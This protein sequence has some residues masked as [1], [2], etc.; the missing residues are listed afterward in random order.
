[1][2]PEEQHQEFINGVVRILSVRPQAGVMLLIASPVGLEIMSSSSDYVFQFGILKASMETMELRYSETSKGSIATGEA[3][4][5]E[6]QME[7]VLSNKP[8][9]GIN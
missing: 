8:K 4:A 6:V 7:F 1:M 5:K 2:T 3:A 9:G